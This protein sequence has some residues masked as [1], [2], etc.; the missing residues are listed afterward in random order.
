MPPDS[1][2][3]RCVHWT[4]GSGCG[5]WITCSAPATLP[6]TVMAK[7]GVVPELTVRNMY[8]SVP[9]PKSKMRDHVL[10]SCG[11]TQA[12]IVKSCRLLTIPFGSCT[13]CALERSSGS[14]F[15]NRPAV[16]PTA[17]VCDGK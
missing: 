2:T 13:Y 4:S 1:V 17:T 12:E 14:A 7:H 8:V 5:A 3:A 6:L 9:E 16:R 11:L 10:T 15:P